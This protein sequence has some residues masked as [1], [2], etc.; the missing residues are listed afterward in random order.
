MADYQ[1]IPIQKS[2]IPYQFNIQL[3]GK[4]FIFDIRYNAQGDF[5]TVDLYHNGELLVAAEKIVYGRLLFVNQ[6]HLGVPTVPIIPYDL[7]MNEDRVNWDNFNDTV[8][9]W[10]PNGG[11]ENG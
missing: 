5:F 4:T 9:L 10:L 11:F 6:Q 2:L 1:F 8:F 7:A 3:G